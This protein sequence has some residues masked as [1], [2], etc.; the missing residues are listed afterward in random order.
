MNARR[1]RLF[2]LILWQTVALRCQK[3]I[4]YDPRRKR[5]A[6]CLSSSFKSRL[7]IWRHL[8]IDAICLVR[9][10]ESRVTTTYIRCQHL[11]RFRC[12]AQMLWRVVSIDRPHHVFG[13]AGKARDFPNRHAGLHLVS[14]TRMPESVRCRAF[15]ASRPADRGKARLDRF[16]RQSFPLHNELK[17]DVQPLPSADVRKQS[18]R[19]CY[20]RSKREASAARGMSGPGLERKWQGSRQY[21]KVVHISIVHDFR[22]R[23]VDFNS[24]RV[25]SS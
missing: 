22:H 14:D 9:F 20:M 16:D 23:R 2:T 7:L 12:T 18:A 21:P 11:S 19:H 3:Q 1:M 10:H 4:A 25:G 5:Q 15:N 8:D 6:F 24:G 13:H 17:A